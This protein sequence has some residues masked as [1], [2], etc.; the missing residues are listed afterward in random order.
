MDECLFCKIIKGEVPSTK[1]Y[2]DDTVF[3][4][5]DIAPVN[6]GHTLVIPKEHSPN[7]YE[8]DDDT[9][10]KITAVTKKLS[11][12]IKKALDADGINLEMNN[13]SVAG[14]VIFHAH[15]HIVPRFEGDGLKHWPGKNYE[16]GHQEEVAEKIKN[17]LG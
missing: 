6:P 17:A 13:D 9:L 10:C 2:E 14:Q 7:L 3:A 8:I 16:G 4:F 12:A 11:I 5:L 1:V 15:I